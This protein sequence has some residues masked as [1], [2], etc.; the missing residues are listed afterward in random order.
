MENTFFEIHMVDMRH[1]PVCL[2]CVVMCHDGKE[3]NFKLTRTPMVGGTILNLVL[4][5][6]M[7]NEKHNGRV[8]I[9]ATPRNSWGG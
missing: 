5:D 3:L 8:S 6:Q 9:G 7:N 4:M 1:K 2:R